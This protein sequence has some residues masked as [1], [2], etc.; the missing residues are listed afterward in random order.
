MVATNKRFGKR[1]MINFEIS[2]GYM[3][4]RPYYLPLGDGS[5]KE[6][7]NGYLWNRS[8]GFIA[9][10]VSLSYSYMITNYLSIG[11]KARAYTFNNTAQADGKNPFIDKWNISLC[12]TALRF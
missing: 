9:E 2:A 11:V 7:S 8:N 3:W 5:T 4:R 10:S 12:L 6:M 1:N